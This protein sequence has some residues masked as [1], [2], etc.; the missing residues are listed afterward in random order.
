MGHITLSKNSFIN[1]ANYYTKILKNKQKLCMAL[2]DNAYGHGITNIANMCDEYGIRH[3]IVRDIS[4]AV[5]LQNNK[6]TSIL[7]LYDIANINYNNNFVFAINCIDKISL[8]AKNSKIELKIDTG[9]SRNGILVSQ[10][11]EAITL[12][13]ENELILNGVF[14]HFSSADEANDCTINQEKIFQNAIKEIKTYINTPFRIHCCNTA[15]VHKVDNDLYDIARIGIGMYGYSKA[16]KDNVK[17]ILSLYANKISSRML[18]TGDSVGYGGAF[19][20]KQDNT[21]VSNYDIGYGD[22]FFR[23]NE[24]QNVLI[25]NGKSILGKVSMDSFSVF[26]KDDEICV[27]SNASALSKV[28]NTIEYEILTHLLPRIKRIVI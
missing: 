8:F 5:S 21:M 16:A 9:M 20:I 6:F 12:I 24:T 18:N 15:S 13:K 7:I 2:K 11:K 25:E 17:P 23:V 14:T 28:H 27:F 4:E 3:C 22:G 26:G 19:K 10:I 1:N